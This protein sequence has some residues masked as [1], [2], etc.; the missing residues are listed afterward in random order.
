M[1][2]VLHGN[3]NDWLIRIA[4]GVVMLVV[5]TVGVIA[6]SCGLKAPRGLLPKHL[7]NVKG[8]K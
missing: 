7:F 6:H 1:S 4:A 8:F 2:N 5:L 3:A